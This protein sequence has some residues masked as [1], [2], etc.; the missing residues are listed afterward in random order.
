MECTAE[1]RQ[2]T[3]AMKSD[4]P[5]LK[6]I[7]TPLIFCLNDDGGVV[8]GNVSDGVEQ[9]FISIV[10]GTHRP[11][12]DSDVIG[13][14]SIDFNFD[15]SVVLMEGATLKE[16]ETTSRFDGRFRTFETA[17]TNGSGT[18]RDAGDVPATTFGTGDS[19]SS[20][21]TTT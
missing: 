15:G 3:I 4:V 20:T 10:Q 8:N 7:P 13:F 19:G 12:F 6:P 11:I 18:A 16:S 1:Q 21:G 17:S 9:T 2:W 5:P 14:M